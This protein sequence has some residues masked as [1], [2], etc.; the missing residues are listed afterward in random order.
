M[1]PFVSNQTTLETTSL[2]SLMNTD[3]TNTEKSHVN[4]VDT[5]SKNS[6]IM[7]EKNKKST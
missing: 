6:E 3:K 1:S 2:T 5:A 7:E 4:I